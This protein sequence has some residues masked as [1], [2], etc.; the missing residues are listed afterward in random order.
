MNK[1][2][3]RQFLQLA[4]GAAAL[5]TVPH[6][7]WAQSYPSRNVR[8]VVPVAPGGALDITA[9]L[10]GQW[11]TE[12]LGQPFVIENRPG[13]GTNIGIESVVRSAPDG[14]TL[15]LVPGSVSINAHLY[16]NLKF[17]FLRDIVPIAA[18]S[19][20]PLVMEV[21]LKVP[22]KT[23]SEFIAYVK[24][25]PGKIAA[26]SGGTGSS[27]H[28]SIELLKMMT[29]IDLVHVPYR[30]G[31]PALTDLMGGQ[32]QVVF[33]P[34][35]ESI[36]SI[37]AGKVRALAVTTPTRAAALPDLP[38]VAETLPGFETSTWNG[39]GAPAKTP[40]AIVDKLNKAVNAAL[41][42]PKIKSQIANLGGTPFP[43][44]PDEFR[45][46]IVEETERAGK[47]IR[48]AHIK[49]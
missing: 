24:A 4:A 16:N 42:D 30:G 45:K 44:T 35:P 39:M 12:H 43:A 25:N 26:G 47:V 40:A 1:L 8:W 28:I 18:I 31:A 34:L 15:L 48:A 21:N 37:R 9:R 29:G 36:Q 10:M 22:A 6:S 19:R 20:V 33:S 17:N 11:L 5:S 46:F 38:T 7:A 2:A 13:A 49:R 32:V 3:R 41:A 27:A 23:V 14:Y